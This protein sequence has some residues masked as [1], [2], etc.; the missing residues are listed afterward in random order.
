MGKPLLIF[1]FICDGYLFFTG[2]PKSY[3]ENSRKR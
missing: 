2:G 1:F 3:L